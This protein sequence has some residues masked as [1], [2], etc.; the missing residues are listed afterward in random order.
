MGSITE[1]AEPMGHA[2][3]LLKDRKEL[4]HQTK[5]RKVLQV[6]GTM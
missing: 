2:V 3:W 1:A 5:K 4:T 6:E